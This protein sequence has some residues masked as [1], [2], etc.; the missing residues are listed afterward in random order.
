MK[1]WIVEISVGI[2]VFIGLL[3]V[4][5]LTIKLGKM[6]WMG[7]GQY[8]VLARFGNVSGLKGGASVDMA[9]VQIGQVDSVTLD[10]ERNVALVKMKIK[11]DVALTEDVFASVKTAGLIGDKYVKIEPGGSDFLLEDGDE[12]IETES[13]IDL[14]SLISKYAFGDVNDEKK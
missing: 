14:E 1:K 11:N 7:G 3:C 5:W 6:E 13:A 4:A 2:F 9:G 12:I 8:C 10:T